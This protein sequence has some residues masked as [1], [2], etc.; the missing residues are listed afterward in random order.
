[1]RVRQR[2]HALTE[3]LL[4]A[5]VAVPLLLLIPVVGKLQDLRHATLMASR[6]V[7][8]DATV[9]HDRSTGFTPAD[10][11]AEEVRARH[12]ARP[13][14]PLRTGQAAPDTADWARPLWTDPRGRPLLGSPAQVQVGWGESV[15]ADPREGFT[16]ARDRELFNRVPG[17]R[18]DDRGHRTPGIL[19]GQVL[20]SVARLPAGVRAWEPFDR[21]DL[22]LSGRTSL[23]VDGWTARSPSEVLDRLHSTL[24][25]G[26]PFTRAVAQVGGLGIEVLE[27]GRL[28]APRVGDL[29]PWEDV[30]PTDRLRPSEDR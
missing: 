16:P 10:R 5:L 13:D 20:V 18:A 12:F 29:R 8:F 21:L 24:P 25:R 28:P 19:T 14:A 11:L 27:L 15:S 26:G 17:A 22:S 4:L 7:A 23:L 2:G 3:T 6:S 9:H 30:V 1:M